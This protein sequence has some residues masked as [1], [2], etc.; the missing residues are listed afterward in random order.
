MPVLPKEHAAPCSCR[1]CLSSK[2]SPLLGAP[3]SAHLCL[4]PSP[5]QPT[6][7]RCWPRCT[8]PSSCIPTSSPWSSA[9]H[10]WGRGGGGGR[11]FRCCCLKMAT[12]CGKKF[13]PALAVDDVWSAA[14]PQPAPH[15]V[16]C[17]PSP[18]HAACHAR[19]LRCQLLPG[20]H[21]RGAG[22]HSSRAG[23]ATA[24]GRSAAAWTRGQTTSLLSALF[25]PC[26]SRSL[27]WLGG[28]QCLW[29]A[30]RCGPSSASDGCCMGHTAP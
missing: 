25:L 1:L 27:D 29:A 8:S 7:A 18:A 11:R 15:C 10:R 2:S 14:W 20:W 24:I 17:C 4:G 21:S 5:L 28:G 23:G 13:S 9:A 3:A 30:P 22:G 19:L 6:L 26:C 16:V 12:Q